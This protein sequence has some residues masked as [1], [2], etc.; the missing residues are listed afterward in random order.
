MTEGSMVY[1]AEGF[2]PICCA[3]TRFEAHNSWFR[4]HLI[5]IQCR[6][7]PRERALAYI[8]ERDFPNWRE[9]DIHESSP[10]QRG[11]SVKMAKEG[12]RY[13]PTQFFSND[14]RGESFRGVRNENLEG[15][16]FADASFDLVISLDVMEHVNRPDLVLSD[17]KR[18]L[19]GGGAYVFTAPTYKHKVKSERRALYGDDGV[20]FYAEAE[21]H[22]NPISDKGSLVTFHYGYDL[23]ELIYQ[24]SEMNTEVCRF[25][26][27]RQGIIGEFTEVYV[28]RKPS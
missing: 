8:L 21:Y 24:W 14:R 11:I 5:C 12:K 17:I 20:I 15:T 25:Q 28:V 19:R 13:I 1:E 10:G 7:I 16:T 4:D 22:G 23:P 26:D 6:S 2:C 3:K 27:Y 9:L 18:T